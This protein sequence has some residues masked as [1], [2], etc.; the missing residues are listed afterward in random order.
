MVSGSPGSGRVVKAPERDSPK[1]GR[2]GFS[3]IEV[4]ISIVILSVGLLGTAGTTVLL[5][6]Q[7]TLADMTTDRSA[8]LQSTI[9][10]LRAL[11]FD[12]VTA[13]YD[14]V[15]VFEVS[16]MV[17]PDLRWKAVEI[18]TTGPGLVT[19]GGFP[20]VAQSV[21]DTFTYRILR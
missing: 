15:G 16:W 19:G 18:V 12:S 9:E 2:G 13:G 3:I 5:V 14:S 17:S 11:P 4:I 6:R 20:T 1:G 10:R 21:A 7:T 8:A